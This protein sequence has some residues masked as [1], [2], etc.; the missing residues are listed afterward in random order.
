MLSAAVWKSISLS[1]VPQILFLFL[2]SFFLRLNFV[3]EFIFLKSGAKLQKKRRKSVVYRNLTQ[4][5]LFL[6]IFFYIF[7]PR[8]LN[9]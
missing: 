7:A 8:F 9:K 3:Q 5:T 2:M 1:L 4:K 6:F